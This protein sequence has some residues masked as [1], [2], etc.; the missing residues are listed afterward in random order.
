MGADSQIKFLDNHCRERE[1]DLDSDLDLE[2]EEED[3]PAKA[4]R[5]TKFM[6]THTV[7]TNMSRNPLDVIITLAGTGRPRTHHDTRSGRQC[8][9]STGYFT[10]VTDTKT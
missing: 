4:G 8:D 9:G 3:L 7:V 2:E 1:E 5:K 6:A 10:C